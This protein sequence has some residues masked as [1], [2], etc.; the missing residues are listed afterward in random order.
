MLTVFSLLLTTTAQ[1]NVSWE[2]ESKKYQTTDTKNQDV[3][4]EITV[5]TDFLIHDTAMF[6]A[7]MLIICVSFFMSKCLY[8]IRYIL[9]KHY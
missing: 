5:G 1:L 9:W 3:S 7:D 8:S 6:F 2:P 4:L